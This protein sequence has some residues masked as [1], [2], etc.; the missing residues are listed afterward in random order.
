MKIKI[1]CDPFTGRKTKKDLADIATL[2]DN[3]SIKEMAGFFKRAGEKI[4]RQMGSTLLLPLSHPQ[5]PSHSTM[6]LQ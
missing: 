6:H 5:N 2:L 3:F 1:I 4:Q